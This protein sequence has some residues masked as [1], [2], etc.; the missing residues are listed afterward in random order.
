VSGLGS[1]PALT[2]VGFLAAISA[3]FADAGISLNPVAGYYHD[4]LFVPW[5]ER[6]RVLAVLAALSAAS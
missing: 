3:A 1:R 4:H 6:E 2:A 5:D